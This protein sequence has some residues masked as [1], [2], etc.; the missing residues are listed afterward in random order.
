MHFH[1]PETTYLGVQDG[2]LVPERNYFD[3]EPDRGDFTGTD[4][5]DRHGGW[6][7]HMPCVEFH[8]TLTG[9]MNAALCADFCLLTTH[10]TDRNLARNR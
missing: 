6:D 5:A 2:V 9:V 8:H 10:T 4:I 7:K 3:S 1:H